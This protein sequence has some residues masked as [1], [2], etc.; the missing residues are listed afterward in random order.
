MGPQDK[1]NHCIKKP[2]KTSLA[3]ATKVKNIEDEFSKTFNKLMAEMEKSGIQDLHQRPEIKKLV[4]ASKNVTYLHI[5]QYL[6]E[7]YAEQ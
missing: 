6:V 5:P 4:D 3:L 7:R 1:K 2:E